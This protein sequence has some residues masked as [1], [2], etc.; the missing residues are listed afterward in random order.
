[1]SIQFSATR[2]GLLQLCVAI[3]MTLSHTWSVEAAE[4]NSI[5]A[6][7][8]SA[9]QLELHG[10]FAAAA[11]AY[12][13]I[14]DGYDFLPGDTKLD[15]HKLSRKQKILFA[16]RALKCLEKGMKQRGADQTNGP[17]ATMLRAANITLEMLKDGSKQTAQK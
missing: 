1:M 10:Q 14:I 7:I 15:N 9:E 11:S 5:R 13:A 6:A 16:E 12:L 2:Q 3:S 17:E 8:N 4:I